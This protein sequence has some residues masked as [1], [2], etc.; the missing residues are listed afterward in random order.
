MKLQISLLGI[1]LSFLLIGCATSVP[2]KVAQTPLTSSETLPTPTLLASSPDQQMLPISAQAQIGSQLIML[3][4]ARTPKEQEIGLMNRT[5]L[6]ADR[7]MLFAFVPPQPV[8]FWMKNTL[9]P[10][11]IIYLREG[12]VKAIA[13]AVPPCT[14]EPCPTY[15]SGVAIDQVIEL[16]SGRA[17]ELGLKVGDRINIEFKSP[18]PPSPTPK[19]S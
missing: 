14:T 1:T 8:S 18:I 13:S 10:L 19:N 5:S 17:T 2:A 4:V 16:R 15:P 12:Q 9:I 11:D 7:G 6:A 3:E